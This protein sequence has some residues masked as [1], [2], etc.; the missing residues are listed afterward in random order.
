MLNCE[1]GG[2]GEASAGDI[3][4]GLMGV[5]WYF[6]KGKRIKKRKGPEGPG[7]LQHFAERTSK[8]D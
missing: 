4:S 6:L 1:S 7:V 8:R 3:D 2:Q 5:R